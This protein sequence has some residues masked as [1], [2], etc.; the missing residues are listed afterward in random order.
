M[1]I[2]LNICIY[3]KSLSETLYFKTRRDKMGIVPAKEKV[4]NMLVLR[5]IFYVYMLFEKCCLD[6]LYS[7]FLS[8]VV[9]E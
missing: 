5:F 7:L 1:Y 9:M 4:E 6:D 2:Y 8:C 3:I